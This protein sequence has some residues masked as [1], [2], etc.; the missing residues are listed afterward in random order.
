[1]RGIFGIF[2]VLLWSI[3]E[4][5]AQT[6]DMAQ[7]LA[8]HKTPIVKKVPKVSSTVSLNSKAKVASIISLLQSQAS[9][10][11]VTQVHTTSTSIRSTKKSA[12]KTTPT[13]VKTPT[14]AQS[15]L[16][17]TKAKSSSKK[18]TT[19]RIKSTTTT[20]SKPVKRQ[21]TSSLTSSGCV[22][23]PSGLYNYVTSNDT[24]AGFMLETLFTNTS[25][26]SWLAPAGYQT[27]FIS[28]FGSVTTTNYLGFFQLQSYDTVKCSKI[29]SATLGCAAFNI[30]Y[31]RDP[32][33]IPS[34]DCPNPPSQVSISCALWG[35]PVTSAIAVNYGQ[36]AQNFLKVITGSSA[37]NANPVPSQP[38]NYTIPTA[39][40]GAI[41]FNTLGYINSSYWTTPFDNALCS[42][43]CS[44]YTQT[45]RARALSLGNNSY[46][47]CNYFNSFNL[48]Y[49][50]NYQG[51]YCVLY[52][53]T[54]AMNGTTT[55]YSTS[56]NNGVT[57]LYNITNSW[58]TSLSP[59][60]S[61]VVNS[62]WTYLPS[63]NTATCSALN[64]TSNSF[65]DVNAQTWT[66]ACGYDVPSSYNLATPN[67]SSFHS[68][69]A[70]CDALQS[71]NAF[72]YRTGT[73][74][75]KS[76]NAAVYV[77]PL[78]STSESDFAWNPASWNRVNSVSLW[79]TSLL[80]EVQV[81]LSP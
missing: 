76:L 45:Q 8:A 55:T 30:Y 50:G 60:D 7:A 41:A 5:N 65:V 53:S 29:C 77:T 52:N 74:F 18:I 24:P 61:G 10:T 13:G 12:I 43:I 37:Y 49:Q 54:S 2:A 25:D 73:C 36:A 67:A 70:L 27:S 31:E 44:N 72:S 69:F 28:Q 78:L 64:S 75:L 62:T 46:Q 38:T 48:T 47:P 56:N 19:R 34:P 22:P 51:Q 79:K 15:I 17:N 6:I 63:D 80:L 58:G 20:K 1:M 66:L 39:L 26:S 14:K 4:I 23:A 35:V 42:A 81:Q 57:Y 59:A 40:N 11:R 9:K 71:C 33:Y 21:A 16:N 32:V 68:C 3:L